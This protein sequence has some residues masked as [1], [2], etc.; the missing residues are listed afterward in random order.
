[1]S[2]LEFKVDSKVW[3]FRN[4]LINNKNMI[5][6]SV[7]SFFRFAVLDTDSSIIFASSIPHHLP[8]SSLYLPFSSVNLTSGFIEEQ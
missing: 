1:M 7:S 5:L 6:E 8:S 2:P 4:E 3:L